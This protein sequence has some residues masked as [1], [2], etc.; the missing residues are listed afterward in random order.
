[1]KKMNLLVGSYNIEP[2]GSGDGLS[3]VSLDL[4]SGK[5]EKEAAFP[6]CRNPSYL[7]KN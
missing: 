4:E 7:A 6:G 3:L 1:M 5:L 2:F